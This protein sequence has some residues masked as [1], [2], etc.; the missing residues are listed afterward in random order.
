M[1]ESDLRL[2]DP[3]TLWAM[4]GTSLKMKVH[5][6]RTINISLMLKFVKEEVSLINMFY[7][8]VGNFSCD[9]YVK[10]ARVF[11]SNWPVLLVNG[12][13]YCVIYLMR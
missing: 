11:R 4:R 8:Y 2:I 9:D 13:I 7:L 6:Y 1:V 10:K 3:A 12:E 5:V